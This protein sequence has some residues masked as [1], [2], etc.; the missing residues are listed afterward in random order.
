MLTE[1]FERLQRDPAFGC[2][3]SRRRCRCGAILQD[4]L[5][6]NPLLVYYRLFVRLC[7]LSR[8]S[9]DYMGLPEHLIGLLIDVA[10]LRTGA[11]QCSATDEIDAILGD[12][13]LL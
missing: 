12:E 8:D 7:H 10:G 2:V 6:H 3:A 1:L 5:G 4:E 11:A 9:L 13:P